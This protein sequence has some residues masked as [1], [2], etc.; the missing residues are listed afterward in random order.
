MTI[1]YRFTDRHGGTGSPPYDTFNL[2]R[3]VGDHPADVSR[4]RARLKE[5]LGMETIVWMEQVHGARIEVVTSMHLETVPACDAI[6]TDNPDIALAVMV[7]DCIPILMYDAT[8]GVVAAVHAGRNGTFLKIAPKTVRTL[9]ERFGCTPTDIRVVM[10]PSIHACCYEIG[11]DLAAVVEKNFG[12]GY[13]N[14]RSLDLQ[15]L[16][17]DQ[18][19]EAGVGEGNIE[20]SEV[21]TCCDHDYFSYRREGT[22]GRFAGVIWMEG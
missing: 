16:N 14:G 21:C 19:T 11:D 2:A 12:K 22:T 9:Q 8:K 15:K 18:L 13:M 20:I 10:G 5:N 7:A 6:V 4:N 17:R 3:H 1:R